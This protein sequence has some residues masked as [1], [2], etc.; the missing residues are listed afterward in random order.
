[1]FTPLTFLKIINPYTITNTIRIEK[2]LESKSIFI[3][4]FSMTL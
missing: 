2:K 1:M 3:F 4:Y